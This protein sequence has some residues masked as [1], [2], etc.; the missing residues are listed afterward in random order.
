MIAELQTRITNYDNALGAREGAQSIKTGMTSSLGEFVKV[1]DEICEDIGTLSLVTK[2]TQPEFYA[3]LQSALVI[4]NLGESSGVLAGQLA[5][6]ETKNL[7]KNVTPTTKFKLSNRGATILQYFLNINGGPGTGGVQVNP[8]EEVI[9]FG[10]E[11][12][13]ADATYLNVTNV[14][15]SENGNYRVKRYVNT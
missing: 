4:R 14:N 3:A 13:N 8:G 15:P 11:L 9:K 6:G 7:F 10:N 12:G 5:G 1:M 2:S